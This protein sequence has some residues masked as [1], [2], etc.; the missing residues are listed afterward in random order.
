MINDDGDGN[1]NGERSESPARHVVAV[2]VLHGV[3]RQRHRIGPVG[4]RTPR[5][6]GRHECIATYEFVPPNGAWGSLANGP[7]TVTLANNAVQDNDSNYVPGGALGTFTVTIPVTVV[8]DHLVDENDGNTNPGQLSLR[9]AIGLANAS[10]SSNN[11]ITFAPSLFTSGA[12]TMTLS[13]VLGTL[14][15]TK[16]VTIQGPG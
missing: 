13:A 14:N 10:S 8:V 12:Q 11:L 16:N 4:Q 7:Y 2:V 15:I 5:A 9:E 1:G 3:V 6:I